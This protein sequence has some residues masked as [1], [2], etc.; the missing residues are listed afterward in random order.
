MEKLYLHKNWNKRG[1]A[2]WIVSQMLRQHHNVSLVPYRRQKKGVLLIYNILPPNLPKGLK[3][4]ALIGGFRLKDNGV[5]RNIKWRRLAHVVFNSNFY[6]KICLS[7]F[8]IKKSSVIHIL[9]GAPADD[10]MLVP[11]ESHI[12]LDINKHINFVVCAKWW[13]R[14][15]KRLRQSI[16]LF[17]NFILPKY[18]NSTL[19]VLG[20][21]F[22]KHKNNIIFHRKSFH[23]ST[24]ADVYRKSH[25]QL[26]LTPFDTGPLTLTESLHYKL[27]FIC[28]TNC[29]GPEILELL[30]GKAGEVVTIDRT[31]KSIRMLK[32]Y[33]PT[34]NKKHYDRELNYKR[35]LNSIDTIVDNYDEY[36]RWKWTNSF[37]YR[38]QSEKWMKVLFG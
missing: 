19:R 38:T 22:G 5:A 13:K 16:K 27:P 2:L 36:I 37:N 35:I 9:G 10:Q 31:I 28:S 18:P 21:K 6:R 25:I 34:T 12:V 8:S 23:N 32:R 15:F 4:V 1:S 30:D 17:N 33:R 11:D 14:S 7:G 24:V 20:S 29:A 3:I 26:I